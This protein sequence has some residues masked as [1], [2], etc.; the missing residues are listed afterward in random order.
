MTLMCYV[1]NIKENRF[2]L[3]NALISI[4]L[5]ICNIIVFLLQYIYLNSEFLKMVKYY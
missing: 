4:N 3:F 5:F 1:H 2:M